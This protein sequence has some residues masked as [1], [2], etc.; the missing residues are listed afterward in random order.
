MNTTAD[1]SSSLKINQKEKLIH[2]IREDVPLQPTV[3][4]SQSTEITQEDQV[5]FQ[6]EDS[7]LPSEEKLWQ[8]RQEK[9]NA[10]HTRPPVITVSYCYINGDCTNTLM[11]SM[12]PFNRVPRTLI[13]K[14]ADPV[15]LNFKKHLLGLP[16]DEQTLTTKPRYT[17]YIGE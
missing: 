5:F 7:D 15:L 4:N 17:H 2:K 8:R 10:V 9:H 1:F 14:I 13:G 12:E 16:F 3:V 11:Q 6:T